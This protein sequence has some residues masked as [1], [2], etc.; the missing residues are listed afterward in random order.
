MAGAPDSRASASVLLES[1]MVPTRFKKYDIEEIVDRHGGDANAA[2]AEMETLAASNSILNED[3]SEVKSK[4]D[5]KAS[6]VPANNVATAKR[7]KNFR[8]RKRITGKLAAAN[9]TDVAIVENEKHAGSEQNVLDDSRRSGKPRGSR[10]RNARAGPSK[11]IASN[12]S[13]RLIPSKSTPLSHSITVTSAI[14]AAST[15][16]EDSPPNAWIQGP[17]MSVK[18]LDQQKTV[19]ERFTKSKMSAKKL[20]TPVDPLSSSSDKLTGSTDSRATSKVS[21]LAS[22]EKKLARNK[23]SKESAE[24]SGKPVVHT[25]SPDVNSWAAKVAQVP[26]KIESQPASSV[27]CVVVEQ[28]PSNSKQA[29]VVKKPV[30]I[31]PP[32][33]SVT[34]KIL[35]SKPQMPPV[36]SQNVSIHRDVKLTSMISNSENLAATVHSPKRGAATPSDTITSVRKEKLPDEFKISSRSDAFAFGDF[37]G[38]NT[39]SKEMSVK[40]QSIWEN[41]S[42][43]VPN[44]V[45][46]TSK[47]PG[48]ASIEASQDSFISDSI[49][50]KPAE[51]NS[52]ETIRTPDLCLTQSITEGKA[53]N[54]SDYET[55]AIAQVDAAAKHKVQQAPPQPVS[56]VVNKNSQMMP[57]P[58]PAVQQQRV[59]LQIPP[60]SH[61]SQQHGQQRASLQVPHMTPPPQHGQQRAA[62]QI[63]SHSH[64]PQQQGQPPVQSP[65]AFTN[66]M[67]NLNEMQSH[68]GFTEYLQP[69]THG[70]YG[71]EMG[72]YQHYEPYGFAPNGPRSEQPVAHGNYPQHQ[73][74]VAPPPGMTNPPAHMAPTAH[75][76]NKSQRSP[77]GLQNLTPSVPLSQPSQQGVPHT[78]Q[79]QP[80]GQEQRQSVANM[81]HNYHYGS[82]QQFNPQFPVNPA[83]MSPPYYP[84]SYFPFPYPSHGQRGTYH[85]SQFM[86]STFDISGHPSRPPVNP[87][88]GNVR[89]SNSGDNLSDANVAT[90]DSSHLPSNYYAV[91]GGFPRQPMFPPNYS[92]LNQQ[93]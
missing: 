55:Q 36:Q 80:A 3:W 40:S 32:Y 26:S 41:D 89:D 93:K 6:A 73:F 79:K 16:V 15:R 30:M 12:E 39:A 82:P 76:Q 62:Y 49:S 66:T 71:A 88:S 87:R 92:S 58:A 91:N 60:Q 43:V 75:G 5:R 29:P 27:S 22:D 28:I 86:Q 14:S 70:Y 64:P 77:I 4:K 20:S 21:R 56:P 61:P 24:V 85:P 63:P 25:K 18:I 69:Q 53:V 67:H 34:S 33:D 13:S 45:K 35:S 78:T 74:M 11:P 54:A 51:N 37:G 50:N 52:S 81:G 46:N 38:L 19:K 48:I 42:K 68:M 2:L 44:V 90:T 84:Q 72:Q 23:S 8:N 47:P 31:T 83:F 1:G 7:E 65:M 10:N 57:K 9:T 59:S 17:P